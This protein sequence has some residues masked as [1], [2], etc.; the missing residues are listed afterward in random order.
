MIQDVTIYE[1]GQGGDL[2]L[3]GNDVE[4]TSA[5][6]N[7]IYLGLFGGNV[8]QST[9]TLR[10]EDEQMFDFWGNALLAGDT[11]E[12]QYNSLTERTLNQ[13]AINSAG[14]IKVEQAMKQDLKFMADFAEVEVSVSLIGV[15]RVK[16]SVQVNEP[17]N[18]QAKE[19]VFI[20]DSTKQEAITDVQISGNLGEYVPLTSG[21]G[22]A[23]IGVTFTV[24]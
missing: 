14:R 16:L 2:F 15:D 21:I 13:T 17:T 20:W 7:M 23:I 6:W 22:T 10:P 18:Q 4:K 3:M 8:E 19:F 5:L 1:T 24:T 11:P 9:P 12:I